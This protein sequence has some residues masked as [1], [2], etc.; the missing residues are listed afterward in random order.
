[1]RDEEGAGE[2]A[3]RLADDLR[4]DGVRVEFD[5]RTDTSFGRRST[6]W[7]LKGVPVRLEVGPRDLAQGNVTLVR[8]T[9]AEKVA[10]PLPQAVRQVQEALTDAQRG[11]LAEA[12]AFRDDRVADATTVD[13]AVEAS[14]GGWARLPWS[15]LAGEGEHRL[16]EY[17][18]TVRCLQRADGSVPLSEDE[19]DLVAFVGRAY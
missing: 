17:G 19:R 11:L 10:V 3:A 12:A 1:V 14:G 7:E 6:D 16:A 15:V 2:R 18:V 9:E 4:A 8:R 13:E 5:T